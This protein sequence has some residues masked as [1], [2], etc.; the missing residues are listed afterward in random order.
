MKL[1]AGN[2]P[3]PLGRR[4]VP[5]PI[6]SFLLGVGEFA[7]QLAPL[8]DQRLDARNRVA[9]RDLQ[10]RRKRFTRSSCSSR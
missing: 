7:L 1:D 10:N 3:Q 6:A 4:H 9:R 8:V 5:P 2:L